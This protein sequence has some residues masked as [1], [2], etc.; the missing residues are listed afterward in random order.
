MT[1]SALINKTNSI[2]TERREENFEKIFGKISKISKFNQQCYKLFST[3]KDLEKLRKEMEGAMMQ[4][5]ET[6]K[7]SIMGKIENCLKG[8]NSSIDR[9]TFAM[10]YKQLIQISQKHLKSSQKNEF[11]SFL[12]Q[13]F[14]IKISKKSF[15]I[16]LKS[17]L[18]LKLVMHR[19]RHELLKK[20]A[21]FWV[22]VGRSVLEYNARMVK[23][24]KSKVLQEVLSGFGEDWKRDALKVIEFNQIFK[25]VVEHWE[26]VDVDGVKEVLRSIP[27]GIDWFEDRHEKVWGTIVVSW[28]FPYVFS[29]RIFWLI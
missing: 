1:I 9:K 16:F 21:E 20:H 18:K 2:L 27:P 3:L 17:K 29:L 15:K 6:N 26:D 22:K 23:D 5:D 24:V 19:E 25:G 10:P 28:F 4:M 13:N 7:I 14:F 8:I 12:L 11:I